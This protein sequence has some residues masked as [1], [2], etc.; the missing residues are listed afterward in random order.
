MSQADAVS[1]ADVVVVGGGLAGLMV[2][3]LC[4]TPGRAVRLC[5]AADELGGRART[6]R[7]DGFHLNFGPR[8]LYRGP[9]LRVL[10]RLGV[11]APAGPPPVGRATALYEDEPHRGFVSVP[12]LLRTPFLGVRERAAVAALLGTA[13]GRP[14]LA[15]VSAQEWIAGRLPSI[16]ARLAA[17]AVVRIATY[18]GCLELASADAVAGHLATARLGLRYVNGGWQTLVDGV[19]AAALSRGVRIMTGTRVTA[20]A[21]GAR[22]PTVRLAGGT[23]IAARAVVVAGLAPA[24]VSRLLGGTSVAGAAPGAAPGPALHAACLD[25]ALGRLPNPDRP[26]VYGIDEPLYLVA[27]S[28]SARLAPPPGAVIHLVRYEDGV[29]VSPAS[30]RARLERL[31]DCYQPGWRDELVHARFLPRMPVAAA[32]P[33]PGSGL[34]GRAPVSSPDR[35]GVFLAGDWVGGHGLLADAVGASALA[36]AVAVERRLARHDV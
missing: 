28:V 23:E 27:H 31:L 32:L 25:V 21:P 5:E 3:A 17:Q 18:V 9:A 20:V 4:A 33:V 7:R 34:R 12:G 1:D 19:R 11:A 13:T 36:A 26:F 10:R 14:S 15:V 8:A 22:R 24:R 30:A 35:P 16:R 6:T 2:A 29:E